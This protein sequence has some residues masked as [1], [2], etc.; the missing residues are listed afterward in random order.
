M[1]PRWQPRVDLELPAGF[2]APGTASV[3]PPIQLPVA[4]SDDDRWNPWRSKR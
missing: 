3:G 4:H 1:A 2:A